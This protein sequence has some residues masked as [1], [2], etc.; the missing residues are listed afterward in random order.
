MSSLC[1]DAASVMRAS[2][3][4]A[5]PSPTWHPHATYREH[6]CCCLLLVTRGR[7]PRC[8]ML[9]W[10]APLMHQVPGLSA[11]NSFQGILP[12]HQRNLP[13]GSAHFL[14][15]SPLLHEGVFFRPNSLSRELREHVL[16][17]CSVRVK[18]VLSDCSGPC[19]MHCARSTCRN[20]QRTC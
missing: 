19:T 16:S 15:D 11:C 18:S 13:A 3:C 5:A 1:C 14:S 2:G 9:F 20:S 7:L 12:S 8:G 6:D 17:V 10:R 4:L